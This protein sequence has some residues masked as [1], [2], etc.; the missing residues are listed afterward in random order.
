MSSANSAVIIY[1]SYFQQG[2]I[3]SDMYLHSLPTM[4]HISV[5]V[6]RHQ[7]HSFVV[8]RS[9]SILWSTTRQNNVF[10]SLRSHAE[11]FLLCVFAYCFN[12][13]MRIFFFLSRSYTLSSM[14]SL[15]VGNTPYGKRHT[16][17][18]IYLTPLRS[19]KKACILVLL[20]YQFDALFNPKNASE[21]NATNN[22]PT[23]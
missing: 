10:P 3:I 18:T 13:K 8:Q 5:P 14:H 17:Q 9:V 12:F 1:Y 20:T 19:Q 16:S 6:R 22:T 7:Q 2:S 21:T 15:A 23:T 4:G 11:H